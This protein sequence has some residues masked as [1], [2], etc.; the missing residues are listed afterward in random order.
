MT[1]T[2]LVDRA[3]FLVASAFFFPE[4]LCPTHLTS[5]MIRLQIQVNYSHDYVVSYFSNKLQMIWK[6]AN[7]F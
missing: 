2:S 7:M 5:S 6:R 4:D 1:V 3:A